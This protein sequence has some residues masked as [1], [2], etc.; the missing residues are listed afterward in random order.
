MR[1]LP[2]GQ[3][4]LAGCG[5]VGIAL[6]ARLKS[7]GAQPIALRRSVED[8]PSDLPAVRADLT[9][10]E[11]LAAIPRD[12][13]AIVYLASADE[14]T[15]KAYRAAYV[16]GPL[17]LAE[18]I[19]S[20]PFIFVSSTSVYGQDDGSW[21]DEYSATTPSRVTGALIVEGEVA[22]CRLERR[23][24][25]VRFGGIYGPGRGRLLRSVAQGTPCIEEPPQ[26]TNRIH[27]DDCAAVLAHILML[28]AADN[29]YLAVDD[30]P[31]PQH[32]VCDWLAKRL[33][34]PPPPRRTLVTRRDFAAG[35]KRVSN[36]RLRNTGYTFEYP[37]FRQGYAA[38]LSGE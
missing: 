23:T 36:R 6:A 8:L 38:I 4:L 35:S 24:T 27:R 37:S 29:L 32:V 25:I 31:S 22:L 18:R 30:E 20:V 15:A 26:Y 28:S 7:A 2:A 21:V 9:T 10:G 5:Y 13:A 17:R 16:D 19:P 14:R 11:G 12:I 3:I 34:V 33:G 1:T